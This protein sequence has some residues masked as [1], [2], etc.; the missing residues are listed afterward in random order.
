MTTFDRLEQHMK[1]RT[2]LSDVHLMREAC[3]F[4]CEEIDRLKGL[5]HSET[6]NQQGA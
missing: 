2:A 4:L 1:G 5:S 6:H 3:K